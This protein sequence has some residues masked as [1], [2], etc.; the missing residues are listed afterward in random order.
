MKLHTSNKQWQGINIPSPEWKNGM[1]ARNYLLKQDQNPAGQT[2]NPAI[3]YLASGTQDG[4]NGLFTALD[5]SAHPALLPEIPIPS[6]LRQA[7]LP[8]LQI[9]S[10]DIPRSWHLQ[11]P[12]AS[13]AVLGCTFRLF[14]GGLSGPPY[15][16]FDSKTC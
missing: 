6:S 11:H 12:G 4:T 14:H 10:S 16:E 9:F 15:R 13:A 8:C 1:I 3:P 2:P 5:S 7:L